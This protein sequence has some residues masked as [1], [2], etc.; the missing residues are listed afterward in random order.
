MSSMIIDIVLVT[1]AVTRLED[2]YFIYQQQMCLYGPLS[3]PKAA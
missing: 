2:V 1:I 3:R